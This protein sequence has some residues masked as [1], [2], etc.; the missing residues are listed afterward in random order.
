MISQHGKCRLLSL[1]GGLGA[2][3]FY[4]GPD[5]GFAKNGELEYGISMARLRCRFSLNVNAMRLQHCE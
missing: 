5:G 3:G 2:S 4:E 1:G